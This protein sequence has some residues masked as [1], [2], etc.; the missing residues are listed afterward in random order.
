MQFLWSHWA[1]LS[2]STKW[3]WYWKL[4]VIVTLPIKTIM[5]GFKFLTYIITSI[6]ARPIWLAAHAIP[7]IMSVSTFKTDI[8]LY[9]SNN[10]QYTRFRLKTRWIHYVYESYEIHFWMKSIFFII[11]NKIHFMINNIDVY[12][13]EWS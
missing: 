13:N 4:S 2:V 11:D 9:I 8:I 3:L 1:I 12:K 7:V 10:L 5:L 6:T